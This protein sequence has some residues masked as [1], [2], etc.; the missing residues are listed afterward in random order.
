M[1]VAT[2]CTAL[3]GLKRD[4]ALGLARQHLAVEPSIDSADILM[5]LSRHK[6]EQCDP[7]ELDRRVLVKMLTL[8]RV[9]YFIQLYQSP[10]V[11]ARSVAFLVL[12]ILT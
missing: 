10:D 3:D 2:V 12:V 9:M 8:N 7:A 5:D 11:A 4:K 1:G 6:L